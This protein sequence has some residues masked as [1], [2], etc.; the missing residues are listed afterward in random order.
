[1]KLGEE[2]C[3]FFHAMAT[4]RYRRN[5]I[6]SLVLPDGH[7]VSDHEQMAGVAWNA[8]KQRLGTSTD[9]SMRFDLDRLVGRVVGLDA[10]AS[11]FSVEE[12][13][14]VIAKMPIDKSPGPD[15]FNGFFLKKC[16]DI[17]KSD[18]YSL[19]KDF[20]NLAVS[21][22]NINSSFITLV[23]KKPSPEQIGDYRPISL[24]NCCLKF[25]SKM[26]AD[27]LQDRIL[28]CIHKNQYGFIKGR[29]IH[30]CLAWSFEY[31]HQCKAS[32]KPIVILK[33]DFEKAFDSIEH[34]VIYLLMRQKGFPET[35]IGWVKCFL[36][37][38]TSAVLV[39]GVPGRKFRCR[40]GVRQGDPLSPLLFVLGAELLQ[41][42]IND[43]RSRGLL[44]LPLDIGV[45]D[46]P[47]VQYADD[48]ILVLEADSAQLAVLKEALEDFSAS[49]G[50]SINFHKSCMLPVN[51]SDEEVSRLAAEFGCIVGSFPFTYLG[52][53]MGTTRPRMVD[54]MPLV[55]RLERRLT[56]S[57]TFLAYGGRLQL[58]SSC[59]SSMPIHFLCA[60]DIPPGIIKQ[61]VRILRQCLWR[62][63]NPE[64][65]KQALAAWDMVC[66]PKHC[67]GLGI[68]D[69]E[70]QNE[71]L[72]IKNLHK[73]YNKE[74]IPWVHL[75]WRYYADSVPHASKL[76]GSFWWRD[77]MKLADKYRN[78]CSV[79]I[80]CGDSALFWSDNWS[81]KILQDEF[82]RL[83]S[84]AVMVNNSV[85]DVIL[86]EDR[87]S[88]FQLPLSPQAFIEF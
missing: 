41:Y 13:D 77:V 11:Q 82:P 87:T 2:N 86:V 16:W 5:A 1:M 4:E 42:V 63:N 73:F 19:A 65:K 22:E 29:S 25:L 10:L 74:D 32:G 15:G 78:I 40:R 37:S 12:M 33:L 54:F 53:P 17:I 68:L 36:E 88:L 35:F 23:P 34:E 59:L 38:G 24:T 84:F 75:V 44:N 18:F 67:G 57:S 70:K 71:G 46:F 21:L 3:K 45:Q 43:L 72:L 52:L 48:T 14:G 9:I 58:I 20:G 8:Y 76:C 62:G 69:F 30:D 26:V 85:Q 83:Y 55:D 6:S 39:N 60:L 66:K 56:A 27:R 81:G 64:S 49:S 79:K 28:E 50:L 61:I 31:L 47:I 7:V 80:G 51:V